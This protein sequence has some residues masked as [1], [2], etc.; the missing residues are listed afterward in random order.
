M[1]CR[2][3]PM[4]NLAD[5]CF[6]VLKMNPLRAFS[7]SRLFSALAKSS[8]HVGKQSSLRN[9]DVFSIFTS[10]SNCNCHSET[11]QFEGF[12]RGEV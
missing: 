8:A 12:V 1:F 5:S 9:Y 4:Q 3:T 11:L 7:S 6:H 10:G 2:F